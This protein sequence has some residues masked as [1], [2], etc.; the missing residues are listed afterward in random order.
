MWSRFGKALGLFGPAAPETEPIDSVENAGN[1][2]PPPGA[3]SGTWSPTY[4]PEAWLI[5][6]GAP[7]LSPCPPTR[8]WMAKVRTLQQ[9]GMAYDNSLFMLGIVGYYHPPRWLV[10]FDAKW[11]STY[12]PAMRA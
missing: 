3:R 5:P 1:T 9:S 4:S 6:P 2:S 8:Q 7:E 10:D 12:E 11:L